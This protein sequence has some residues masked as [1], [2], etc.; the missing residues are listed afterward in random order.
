MTAISDALDRCDRVVALFSAAYFD[1]SRYTI[2][3][4]SAAML[5]VPGMEQ[6][7]LVPVRVD[8]VPPEK[9]PVVLRSLVHRDLFGRGT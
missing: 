9:V 8:E 3:E 6:G 1:R 4:W 7:R 5:H 2:E